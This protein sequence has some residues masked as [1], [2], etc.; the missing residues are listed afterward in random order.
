VSSTPESPAVPTSTNTAAT[1]G[2]LLPSVDPTCETSSQPQFPLQPDYD[3]EWAIKRYPRYKKSRV[4]IKAPK[5]SKI[6]KAV[7]AVIALQAQGHKRKDIAEALGLTEQ[8]VRNYLYTAHKRGWVN[9][10]TFID[11]EDKLEIVLKS[12]TVRNIN[13]VLDETV[14][15][16]SGERIPS[17]RAVDMTKEVAKG[18]GLFKTHTV[19]KG[20]QAAPI[21]MAL[22]VQVEYPRMPGA[23]DA[24]SLP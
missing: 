10:D 5:D 1:E 4:R 20:V 15:D 2:S 23:T 11:P 14:E 17:N 13:T 7:L 6:Y 3:P 19:D 18:T 16:D 21:A 22:K 12:K 8:T 9:H 24:K